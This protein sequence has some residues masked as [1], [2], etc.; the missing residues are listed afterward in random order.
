ML[1]NNR[2]PILCLLSDLTGEPGAQHIKSHHNFGLLALICEKLTGDSVLTLIQ[3]RIFEPLGMSSTDFFLSSRMKKYSVDS[4]KP[5][6]DGMVKMKGEA[7]KMN[8]VIDFQIF[9][10]TEDMV[11]F[12]KAFLN[13]GMSNGVFTDKLIQRMH[14]CILQKDSVLPQQNLGITVDPILSKDSITGHKI[15]DEYSYITGG[16]GMVCFHD[17]PYSECL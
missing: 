7:A 13:P 9:S 11:K 4:F 8:S 16:Q 5:T 12:M 14:T 10:S 15:E 2:I 17:Y 6:G 1:V 3:G